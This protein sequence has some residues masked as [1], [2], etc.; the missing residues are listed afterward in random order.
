MRL[1]SLDG[2]TITFEAF[3][4][5][6]TLLLFWNPGCGFCQNMLDDLKAWEANPAAEL[7]QLLVIAS[8]TPESNR[9]MNLRS[10]VVLDTGS[11]LAL[12]FAAHGTPMAVLLDAE[13]RLASDVVGGAQAVMAL[14]AARP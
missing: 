1:K 6:P 2:Q 11:H 14:A 7:P 13:G 8:G 5:R 3:R 10:P 9:A 4:G 12:A